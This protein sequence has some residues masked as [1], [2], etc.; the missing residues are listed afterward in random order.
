MKNKKL[1]P[2]AMA[3]VMGVSLF[4]GCGQTGESSVESVS[5]EQTTETNT[6]SGE[7]TEIIWMI[8]NEEPKNFDSVMAAV[9]EKLLKEK[10]MTLDLRCI[11]PGDYD[12]KMQ[13]AMAGGDEW[14]LCFTSHWANNYVNAAGK[15][16]YLELSEEML[17]E[18]A[19]NL[20]ATIPENLWNG[21]KV[22]GNIYALMNYF[23][24]YDQAGM[25]FLKSAVD[26]QGIDVTT[27]NSWES[28]NK[29]IADLAAAYP[30]KYATRGGGVI[31]HDL[32]LQDVPLSTIMNMPFLTYDPETNKVS[33]TLYFDRIQENLASAKE[34]I[35]TK[36]WGAN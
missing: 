23:S 11:A 35:W 24:M 13:M 27:V 14:D 5:G 26:E 7:P 9:N 31:N 25:M 18:N 12:T 33:N 16:A 8:R 2:L 15:G 36:S 6:Q 19:P 34:W 17:N 22:N 3:A 30:D 28:L 32:M 20:M 4:A 21:V 1:F 29:T 10:N